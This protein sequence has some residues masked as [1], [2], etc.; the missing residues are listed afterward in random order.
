M[1]NDHNAPRLSWGPDVNF[2]PPQESDAV[3][4]RE[5]CARHELKPELL[6]TLIE[7]EESKLHS[8]KRRGVKTELR[9]AI[10][11]HLNAQK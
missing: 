10:E 7:I 1:S 3:L 2:R 8:E 4:L 11:R 9:A 5:I 6:Q